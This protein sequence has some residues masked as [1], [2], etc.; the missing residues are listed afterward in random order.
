[1]LSRN[2]ALMGK[3]VYNGVSQSP[4]RG[5]VSG[6]G[7]MGYMRR[8]LNKGRMTANT[9]GR[10][11]KSDSRSGVAKRALQASIHNPPRGNLTGTSDPKPTK[12]GK[13]PSG[14]GGSGPRPVAG[15]PSAPQPTQPQIQIN[16][17]GLL[18]LPYNQDYAAEQLG[19]VQDANEQLMG[20]NAEAQN[21]NL[22]YTT[23]KRDA[24][25]AYDQLRMQTLN[26]NAAGGT[27]FSSMYGTSVANNANAYANQM[28]GLEQANTLF[29]QQQGVQRASIQAALNQQ[30]AALTQQYADELG[31]QAGSLGFGTPKGE[32]RQQGGKHGPRGYHGSHDGKKGVSDRHEAHP[33]KK[34]QE[35]RQQKNK[36]S[37]GS[38]KKQVKR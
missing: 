19:L 15:G 4:N 21:Q 27:A 24:Q 23:G 10:D 26:K 38:L 16:D 18:E 29:N 25:L 35:Q 12:P 37:K 1:M 17:Q 8:E 11:G 3:R 6:N 7:A 14:P 30:I 22:E 32:T 2:K 5:P 13:D 28:G 20:L 36:G 33:H 31:G 9:Q 34:R